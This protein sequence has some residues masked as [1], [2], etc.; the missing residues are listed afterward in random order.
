MNRINVT[1]IVTGFPTDDNPSHGV[2]NKR[3]ADLLSEYVNI[4]VVQLRVLRPGRKVLS[5]VS[6]APYKHYVLSAPYLP[7][8][9]FFIC[10]QLSLYKKF[11]GNRLNSLL[12]HTN[13]IHSVGASFAGA[14]GSLWAENYRKRNVIQLIG[15]DVNSELSELRNLK[16]FRNLPKFTYGVGANTYALKQK[17]EELMPGSENVNVVYRGINV[18]DY[19]YSFNDSDKIKFLFLGGLP[20]YKHVD[21]GKNLKGGMTLLQAWK[22]KEDELSKRGCELIFA[23]PDSDS[24][25][26]VKWKDSL[27][28]PSLVHLKGSLTPKQVLQEL[29][30]SQMLLIPSLEEGMP[31]VALEGG[32]SGKCIIASNVGGLPELIT[33]NETG[34]LIQPGSIEDLGKAMVSISDDL[35][36]AKEMGI[37]LRNRIKKNYDSGNFAVGYL[38]LYEKALKIPIRS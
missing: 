32:A 16:C 8:K 2:F 20:D 25:E 13:I 1:F 3:A 33:N 11:G 35:T 12:L 36:K 5:I 24:D 6:E 30:S 19:D 23:G 15:T 31:N 17:Y 14:L 37:N 38:N 27:T 34:L 4:S 9:P 29:E 21:S 7:P 18:G 22:K 26:A 28:N 10:K